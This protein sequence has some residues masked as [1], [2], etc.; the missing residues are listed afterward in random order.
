MK[1]LFLILILIT[2]LVLRM[3]NAHDDSLLNQVEHNDFSKQDKDIQWEYIKDKLFHGKIDRSPQT[4]KRISGPILFNL[5]NATKIDSLA[6]NNTL[7]DLKKEIPHKTFQYA[8]T[9]TKNSSQH[10]IST[11]LTIYFETDDYKNKRGSNHSTQSLYFSFIENTPLKDRA[12]TIQYELL[13]SIC[14]IQD[15]SDHV[16]LNMN[17]PNNAIFNGPTYNVLN[18]EFTEL[19]KF[20]LKKLY[21]DDFDQQFAHYMHQTYPWRYASLFIN[22]D[23]MQLKVYILIASIGLLVF[24]LSFGLFHTRKTSYFHY[25]FPLLIT[26]LTLINLYWIYN[27]FININTFYTLKNTLNSL[28]YVITS[29]VIMSLLLWF[30]EQKFIKTY[31]GF[32]Y[33]MVMKLVLTLSILHIPVILAYFIFT[34]TNNLFPEYMT[35]CFV[36]LALTLGRGLL[37][38]LNHYSDTLVKQKELEL[39]RL[40]ELNAQNELKSLHAHIN[41]HFLYNALNSIASLMHESTEKAEEMILALSDLFRYSINRKEKKMS[42]IEDEVLMVENYL[43]IEKIRFENRLHFFIDVDQNLLN[44]QIP[45]YILQPLIENAVKHGIAKVEA[46]G[47]II[48]EIKEQQNNLIITISDNGNNFPEDM[49]SGY[50]LQSVYDLLRLSYGDKAHINWTNT[51]KK[52][53]S[54]VMPAQL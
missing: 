19:D 45:M 35:L 6:F 40:K 28:L 18:T 2:P 3:M 36:F 38:Y 4:P 42:T 24:I 53:I 47:E 49:Y 41:P 13:R 33:Q 44:K 1:K 50:G 27:F 26:F 20:L 7:E 32:T 11:P 12:K 14:Y 10:I 54:I 16:F 8:S 17:Y 52:H 31:L 5:K 22:K 9:F 30:I 23:V 15:A 48:L 39:S 29:T 43:K 51:P 34:N 25:F 21:A 46:K 37:I